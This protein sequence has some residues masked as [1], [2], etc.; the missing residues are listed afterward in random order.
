MIYRNGDFKADGNL[1]WAQQFG[2]NIV[3]QQFLFDPAE[4][5]YVA[6]HNVHRFSQT[7][8]VEQG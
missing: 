7:L 5:A 4:F 6:T 1:A 2:T 3:S 8:P